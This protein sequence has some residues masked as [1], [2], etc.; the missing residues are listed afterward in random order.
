MIKPSFFSDKLYTSST[1]KFWISVTSIIREDCL[2]VISTQ[3]IG[4]DASLCETFVVGWGYLKTKPPSCRIY[5]ERLIAV[6]SSLRYKISQSQ[7]QL[8]TLYNRQRKGW[9]L[10]FI[11][12]MDF[13]RTYLTFQPSI[14]LYIEFVC[15]ARGIWNWKGPSTRQWSSHFAVCHHSYWINGTQARR[16]I[17]TVPKEFSHVTNSYFFIPFKLTNPKCDFREILNFLTW[18][19]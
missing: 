14:F 1:T 4:C 16:R 13:K 12:L 10:R 15:A 11:L 3:V 18:S 9:G 7:V 6:G 5:V 17:R 19:Y 2:N 8:L